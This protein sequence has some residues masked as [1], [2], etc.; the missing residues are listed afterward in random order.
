DCLVWA[1]SNPRAAPHGSDAPRRRTPR[2]RRRP[3][4]STVFVA[5]DKS[6]LLFLVEFARDD[7]RLAIFEP[8]PV[9][10]R[11]QSRAALVSDAEFLGDPSA[12]LARRVRQGRRD[13]DFQLFLLLVAQLASA[14]ADIKARQAFQT[15][16]DKQAA[17]FADRIVVHKQRLRDPLAA[18]AGVE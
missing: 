16:L 17:P 11:D 7:F 3:R 6:L 14:A 8:Q 15:V 1:P 18:P 5:R 9:Q 12:D 2:P 13:P 4:N 10:Q